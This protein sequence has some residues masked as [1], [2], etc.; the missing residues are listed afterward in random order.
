M[1]HAPPSAERGEHVAPIAGELDRR[2]KQVRTSGNISQL[3]ARYRQRP[4]YAEGAHVLCY[5]LFFFENRSPYPPISSFSINSI[6]ACSK[7]ACIL[8]NVEA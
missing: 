3:P 8:T 2:G 1:P 6:P 5:R 4:R 7:A